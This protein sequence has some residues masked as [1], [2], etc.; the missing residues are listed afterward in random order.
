MF[1]LKTTTGEGH[2]DL[3]KMYL[4]RTHQLIRRSL[5][6]QFHFGRLDFREFLDLF[7]LV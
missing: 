3:R 7:I 6:D 1:K 2:E 4:N 5:I